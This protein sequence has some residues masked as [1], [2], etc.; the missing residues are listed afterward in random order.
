MNVI[1]IVGII[2]LVLSHL[3]VFF[4][5]FAKGLSTNLEEVKKFLK[6]IE[7]NEKSD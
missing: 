4:A 5:G 2:L 3:I 6:E 1:T 7:D